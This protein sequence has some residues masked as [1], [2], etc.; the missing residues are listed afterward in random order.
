MK[1]S[2]KRFIDNEDDSKRFMAF[3]ADKDL[4]KRVFEAVFRM[5]KLFIEYGG[6]NG[7]ENPATDSSCKYHEHS[8]TE[9]CNLS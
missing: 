4:R 2:D 6:E 9:P 7:V 5:Q 3:L 8:Q 1:E